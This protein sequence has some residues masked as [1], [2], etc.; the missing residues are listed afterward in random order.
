MLI[1]FKNLACE[2]VLKLVSLMSTWAK[3]PEDVI[4]YIIDFVKPRLNMLT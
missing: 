3:I 1:L 4:V 2:M